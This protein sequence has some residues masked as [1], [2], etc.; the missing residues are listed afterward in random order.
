MSGRSVTVVVWCV[1]AAAWV[2]LWGEL[3]AASLGGG[4]AVAAVAM[5][6]SDRVRPATG[7]LRPFAAARFLVVVG[8]NL[9]KATTLVAWEVITPRNRINEGIIAV[10]LPGASPMV[11]LLVTNAIGLT[12]GTVVV[13]VDDDP[14]VLYVHVLHLHDVERVRRDLRALGELAMRGFGPVPAREPAGPGGEREP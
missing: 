13:D 12:P 1:L 5:V 11:L 9:V 4:A 2:S 10:P 3:T 8:W 6:L 7:R 14:C